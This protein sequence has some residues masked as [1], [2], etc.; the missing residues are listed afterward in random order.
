M[1]AMQAGI[2]AT[3]STPAGMAPTH[4]R[5]IKGVSPERL[6]IQDQ[7]DKTEWCARIV[8]VLDGKAACKSHRCA[9]PFDDD[10]PNQS[11]PQNGMRALELTPCDAGTQH[12]DDMLLWGPANLLLLSTDRRL[13]SGLWEQVKLKKSKAIKFQTE[14]SDG[15]LSLKAGKFGWV[16]SLE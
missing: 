15:T 16:E 10:E 13:E 4:I 1:A 14:A 7:A 3:P 2:A 6:K 9:H 8:E 5:P 11:G 12:G